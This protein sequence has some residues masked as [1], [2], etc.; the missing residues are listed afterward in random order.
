MKNT[1]LQSLIVLLFFN[2]FLGNGYSSEKTT[3]VVNFFPPFYLYSTDAMAHLGIISF[4]EDIRQAFHD[5]DDKYSII[6]VGSGSVPTAHYFATIRQLQPRTAAY[7]DMQK[8]L[9]LGLRRYGEGI[10]SH[11][12]GTKFQ[13]KK[14]DWQNYESVEA[15][16]P[17]KVDIVIL[18]HPNLT[19]APVSS[20]RNGKLTTFENKTD[21]ELVFDNALA[22][23]KV[24]GSL[25]VFLQNSVEVERLKQL[26]D[27]RTLDFCHESKK[28]KSTLYHYM[29]VLRRKADF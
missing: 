3:P 6:D 22:R 23:M 10:S 26:A 28:E 5:L 2:S 21:W 27:A 13:F 17:D 9:L 20:I 11:F 25:L 15:K 12:P 8:D 4:Q 19:G 16:F 1:L 29:A 24:D 14:V 18:S 7:S